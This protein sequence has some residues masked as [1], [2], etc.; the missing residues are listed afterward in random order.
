MKSKIIEQ[1]R[2]D[3]LGRDEFV[4]EI[5]NDFTPNKSEIVKDLGKDENLT[6]INKINSYFGKSIFVADIFVYD[7]IEKKEK[8]MIVPKKIRDKIKKEKLEE[9]K[10]IKEKA[11]AAKE[12][13]KNKEEEN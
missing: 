6:V 7:D 5:K 12:A 10:K 4:L 8:F 13:E 2:N 9:E 1:R 11:K 3:F